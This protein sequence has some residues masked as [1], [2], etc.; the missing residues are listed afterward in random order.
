M[1]LYGFPPILQSDSR[2]LILG[3]FPSQA[4][5]N[6]GMYYSHGKNQFWPL[7]ALST[8]QPIPVSRDEKVRLL[9]ESGI[10][11]WDMVASCERKGSLDQNILEP[12]LNDIGG[13]LNSCP[14]IKRILLNGSLAADLMYRRILHYSGALPAIGSVYMWEKPEGLPIGIYRLPSTSPVPTRQFKRL[15][16]KLPLWEAALKVNRGS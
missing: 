12:E 16:D 2:I 5:L 9:T 11:L 1:R 15:E 4:S 7:L 6:A 3:S 10:A 14:T 8:G 13:L